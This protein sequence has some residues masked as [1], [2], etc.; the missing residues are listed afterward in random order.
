MLQ[1]EWKHIYLL[2]GIEKRAGCTP[3]AHL[4][5]TWYTPGARPVLTWYT[6]GSFYIPITW[7]TYLQKGPLRELAGGS[8]VSGG[9]FVQTSKLHANSV[10]FLQSSL[11]AKP[12]T[13]S[14]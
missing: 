9:H 7:L 1:R 8:N 3:G 11:L 2:G 14:L 10:L 13:R 5:H 12:E 4:A 6:P